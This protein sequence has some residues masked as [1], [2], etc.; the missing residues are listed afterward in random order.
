MLTSTIVRIIGFCLR[1]AWAVVVVALIAAAFAGFYAATH[2]AINSD[3]DALLSKDLEWR[4]RELAFE[5]V[6][7]RFELVEVVVQAPTPE[8]TT[9]ATTALTAALAKEKSSFQS[10]TNSSAARFFAQHGMLFQPKDE[11]EKSLAALTDA[12]PLFED[13]SSDQSL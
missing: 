2:F 11:L 5:S 1:R 4:Q 13:L 3:I 12:E 10:V 9:A 6:F 7:Q 8:L